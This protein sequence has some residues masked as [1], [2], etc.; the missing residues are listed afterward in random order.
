MESVVYSGG[1]RQLF[2]CGHLSDTGICISTFPY[3][4]LYEVCKPRQADTMNV[5]RF[6]TSDL[7]RFKDTM[8]GDLYLVLIFMAALFE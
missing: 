7:S 8:D 5:N 6:A 1:V 3:L 4:Y 2:L